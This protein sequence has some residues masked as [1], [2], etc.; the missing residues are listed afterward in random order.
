MLTGQA[1]QNLPPSLP[2]LAQGRDPP[3]T[4][5]SLFLLTLANNYA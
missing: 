3:L 4:H 5:E 1:K 2:T